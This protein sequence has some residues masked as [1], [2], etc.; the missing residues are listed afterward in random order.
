M[1]NT[2]FYGTMSKICRNFVLHLKV[3]FKKEQNFKVSFHTLSHMLVSF[4]LFLP[5]FQT[6]FHTLCHI[7][8]SHFLL[9]ASCKSC[10]SNL[11]HILKPH[12]TDCHFLESHF[13]LW[14]TFY[15]L[16]SH[17]E[18]HFPVSFHTLI[19]ISKFR[20][21]SH[22]EQHS[23]V[24]FQILCHILVCNLTCF[25]AARPDG[26]CP[27]PVHVQLG[28]EVLHMENHVLQPRV[29]GSPVWVLWRHVAHSNRSVHRDEWEEQRSIG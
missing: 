15:T 11:C 13:T 18:P 5:H 1:C 20:L 25:L 7:L 9:C 19:H 27:L 26:Q 28:S 2:L 23:W 22:F 8:K 12:F 24:S 3:S 4:H 10:I 14:A 16:I 29:W 17:F 6:S 21:I